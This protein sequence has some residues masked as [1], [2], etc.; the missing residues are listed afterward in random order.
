MSPQSGTYDHIH[1]KVRDPVRSPLVKL[2][3]AELVVGSV[4]TS[5]SSVLYVFGFLVLLSPP[6]WFPPSSWCWWLAPPSM[7]AGPSNEGQCAQTTRPQQDPCRVTAAGG[8]TWPIPNSGDLGPGRCPS[9]IEGDTSNTVSAIPPQPPS[10]FR[11]PLSPRDHT[12]NPPCLCRSPIA[13]SRTGWRAPP[14]P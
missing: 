11:T 9:G 13:K 6:R 2:V 3:R 4:T 8:F 5:E 10:P 7:V 1:E 14:R 12:H